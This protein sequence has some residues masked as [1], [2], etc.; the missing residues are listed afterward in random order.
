MALDYTPIIIAVDVVPLAIAF[1]A[2]AAIKI[3]PNVAQWASNRIT[4]FFDD[5]ADF[6]EHM[7]ENHGENWR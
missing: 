7:R 6:H 1:I 5:R 3:G 4:Q 2:M